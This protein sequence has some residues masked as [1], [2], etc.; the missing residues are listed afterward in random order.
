LCFPQ[1]L[2]P[3]SGIV[4]EAV[5]ALLKKLHPRLHL[6][7]STDIIEY[8]KFHSERLWNVR[9]KRSGTTPSSGE[10]TEFVAL[11]SVCTNPATRDRFFHKVVWPLPHGSPASFN[12]PLVPIPE[13][14]R[15]AG[16]MDHN[17]D[18]N[19]PRQI[20]LTL[21]LG[22]SSP[23]RTAG[24]IAETGRVNNPT[25]NANR[26]PRL[27]RH[28]CAS[29]HNEAQ[30]NVT[31]G[32][33]KRRK[34]AGRLNARQADA[35]SNHTTLGES[36][37]VADQP[38]KRKTKNN[39][40]QALAERNSQVSEN[41]HAQGNSRNH[42]ERTRNSSGRAGGGNGEGLSTG[43]QQEAAVERTFLGPHV[44]AEQQHY[45]TPRV[46]VRAP[47]ESKAPGGHIDLHDDSSEE[48]DIQILDEEES[49]VHNPEDSDEAQVCDQA[50]DDDTVAEIG[51]TV[52]G[53]SRTRSKDD[54]RESFPLPLPAPDVDTTV[55]ET[56]KLPELITDGQY[57]EDVITFLN[58]GPVVKPN[59]KI[60][61]NGVKP[62]LEARFLVDFT[63]LPIH[64]AI[65]NRTRNTPVDFIDKI[66]S[67]YPDGARTLTKSF[68]EDMFEGEF[69]LD[70]ACKA[71]HKDLSATKR[72]SIAR[73]STEEKVIRLLMQKYPWALRYQTGEEKGTWLLRMME[74]RPYVGLVKDMVEKFDALASLSVSDTRTIQER[75]FEVAD[76]E[77]G[78]LPIH[79]AVEY[80]SEPEVI[81]YLIKSFPASVKIARACDG[82]LPLHSA[83]RYKCF[84]ET[85]QLLLQ[86]FPQAVS[87][88]NVAQMTPL[89]QLF[90]VDKKD[91]TNGRDLWDHSY[92]EDVVGGSRTEVLS[93]DG[94]ARSIFPRSGTISRY[95]MLT[96]MIEEYCRFLE[97]EKKMKQKA[98]VAT[99]RKLLKKKITETRLNEETNERRE[100]V[101]VES[102]YE[103]AKKCYLEIDKFGPDGA[104]QASRDAYMY[105][106]QIITRKT[107]EKCTK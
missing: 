93:T 20:P 33:Q 4:D 39:Q 56:P 104:K 64:L 60:A 63:V 28:Q 11:G 96:S 12:L 7:A 90:L 102:I 80:Y 103:L 70:L 105:L 26:T 95:P 38:R 83:A 106:N 76:E 55:Y 99:I 54:T 16:P 69:A 85:R 25:R 45:E 65:L 88:E 57:Y 34:Q 46:R 2:L 43:R 14:I 52:A 22:L 41:N 67:A 81:T 40:P 51:D 50:Y 27:A 78:N 37:P 58:T 97:I 31:S 94:D 32:D 36:S 17:A 72:V 49:P 10:R 53:R 5:E 100:V 30:D 48:E 66:L 101:V 91:V 68:S 73:G 23:R 18:L 21:D 24:A 107:I 42:I 13:C 92:S 86:L 15:S 71:S 8:R 87:I 6:T 1:Y 75:I 35:G 29:E 98:A 84:D 77:E 3:A 9:R 61:G 62:I 44:V 89:H 82:N 79:L 59:P 74:H 47:E 19:I